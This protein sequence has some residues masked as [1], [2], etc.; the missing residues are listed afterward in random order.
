[1]KKQEFPPGWDAERARR[2]AEYYENQSDDE[3]IAE[4]EAPW[5]DPHVTMMPVPTGLVP[6]MR[7]LI[8]KERNR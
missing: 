1:M 5:R 4:D 3:A 6:V 8:E 7:D 2:V